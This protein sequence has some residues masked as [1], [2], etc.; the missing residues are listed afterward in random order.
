MKS[1]GKFPLVVILVIVMG[2]VG[3]FLQI[4]QKKAEQNRVVAYLTTA[5][6]D[7]ETLV[8]QHD[9]PV[10]TMDIRGTEFDLAVADEPYEYRRGLAY[11]ES[12]GDTQG[13]VYVFPE[14]G[15]YSF[16]TAGMM[17]NLD[18]IWFDAD[19]KVVHVEKDLAP[20]PEM[21]WEPEVDARFV[22][23]V[24]AGTADSR[25]LRVGRTIDI[26]DTFDFGEEI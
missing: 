12:L 15:R 1:M 6:P 16:A 14:T 3:L 23:E 21:L 18:T 9:L 11:L 25:G 22:I 8:A 13:M 2:L 19:G 24:K 10:V 17:F 7:F 20:D 5:Y 4:A 26:A